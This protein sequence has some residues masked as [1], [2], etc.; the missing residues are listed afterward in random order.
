MCA[1]SNRNTIKIAHQTIPLT[2]R[3]GRFASVVYVDGWLTKEVKEE[4]S[5]GIEE[6][7]KDL[8]EGGTRAENVTI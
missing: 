1:S 4:N 2:F 3:K 6:F 8:M 5:I 7:G